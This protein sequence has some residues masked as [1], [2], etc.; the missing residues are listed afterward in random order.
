[1]YICKSNL[2][3]DNRYTVGKFNLRNQSCVKD[4]H[5]P[6]NGKY[7]DIHTDKTTKAGQNNAIPQYDMVKDDFLLQ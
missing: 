7:D 3:V 1:M 6:L 5:I 2:I 4:C